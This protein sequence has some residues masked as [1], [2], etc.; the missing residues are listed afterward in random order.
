[1]YPIPN[2]VASHLRRLW[3]WY[4]PLRERQISHRSIRYNIFLHWTLSHVIYSN[5]KEFSITP[6]DYNMKYSCSNLT[7]FCKVT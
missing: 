6:F 1:M 7:M 4:S 5:F 2:Y 3:T